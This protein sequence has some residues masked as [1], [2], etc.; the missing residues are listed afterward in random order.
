MS[1]PQETIEMMKKYLSAPHTTW[2]VW[3]TWPT[4]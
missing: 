4:R 2:I 3:Q 1:H